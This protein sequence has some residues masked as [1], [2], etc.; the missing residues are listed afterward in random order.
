MKQCYTSY[1][2]VKDPWCLSPHALNGSLWFREKVL[3]QI[4]T[5]AK[6]VL[7]EGG[8]FCRLLFG[9]AG[10][11]KTAIS[12]RVF[13][14]L[15]KSKDSVQVYFNS[16]MESSA[17]NVMCGIIRSIIPSIPRRGISMTELF[18]VFL[19][20]INGKSALIILDDID[21]WASTKNGMK[22][23]VNLSKMKDR[24]RNGQGLYI[25]MTTRSAEVVRRVTENM[26]PLSFGV[27]R[28]EGYSYSQLLIIIKEAIVKAFY[29]GCVSEEA[30]K[31]LA[32]EAAEAGGVHEAF[33]ILM[34]AV[35]YAEEEGSSQIL[36]R[37]V[38][39][40][41]CR[42][43]KE[44]IGLP[45]VE[46]KLNRKL[47]LKAVL[48]VLGEKGNATMG[49]LFHAYSRKCMLMGKRSLGRTQ[50]WRHINELSKKG[51]VRVKVANRGRKGRTTIVELAS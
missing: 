31:I 22:L 26:H 9:E 13:S 28:L 3:E 25:V 5:E 41:I 50:F 7:A 35:G 20:A 36:R 51:I 4:I 6:H 23:I 21:W 18:E 2:L 11:G 34:E 29:K 14:V 32:R 1:F 30:L 33:K 17:Y 12:K 27:T 10:V 8:F 19:D 45:K 40:A 48:E 42:K 49:E 46:R 43:K 38:E 39:K 47:I 37:H 44:E 24:L 16:R 15:E